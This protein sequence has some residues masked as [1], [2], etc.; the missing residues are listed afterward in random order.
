MSNYY[1][2]DR[3]SNINIDDPWVPVS[4]VIVKVDDNHSY[5]AGTTTG[6]TMNIDC[7]IGSQTVANNLLSVFNGFIYRAYDATDALIKPNTELGDA[8][9]IGGIYSIVG[10]LHIEGDAIFAA[11]LS[12]P[13]SG[14]I[15]HEYPY[16]QWKKVVV[17]AKNIRHGGRHGTV[18]GAALTPATVT[19]DKIDIPDLLASI[20]A[21]TIKA[22]TITAT[23]QLVA[24][25]ANITY[26]TCGAMN[27]DGDAVSWQSATVVTDITVSRTTQQRWMYIDSGGQQ[28]TNNTHM[29][30][31]VT[32][33]RS[34]IYYLG[35][36]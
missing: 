19:S 25:L 5:T 14:D 9:S 27:F 1:I 36:A 22:T 6:R 8:V 31:N 12:A 10:G 28:Q 4:Q 30:T 23:I 21:L 32:K 20:E 34:T 18:S 35:K 26:I 24:P 16:N 7:A 2:G 33:D 13:S 17:D 3:C 11:D 29:V 15:D